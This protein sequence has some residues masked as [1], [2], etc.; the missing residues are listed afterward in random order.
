VLT[1]YSASCSGTD[2]QGVGIRQVNRNPFSSLWKKNILNF[3]VSYCNESVL[4]N[5][6][7]KKSFYEILCIYFIN[8]Y[9]VVVNCSLT[10]NFIRFLRIKS[11]RHVYNKSVINNQSVLYT[12]FKFPAS[13][14]IVNHSLWPPSPLSCSR[15]W[16][17][18]RPYLIFY[19]HRRRYV[20]LL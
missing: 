7:L 16:F 2:P 6:H 12:V 1:L 9:Y 11:L 14:T 5:L 13:Q 15:G 8:Y 10:Y 17:A 4:Q 18:P 3:D 20:L 19:L